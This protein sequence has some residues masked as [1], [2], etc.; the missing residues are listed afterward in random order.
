MTFIPLSASMALMGRSEL[1]ATEGS[2]ENLSNKSILQH[3]YFIIAVTALML[4]VAARICVLRRRNRPL[5]EFFSIKTSNFYDN[6]QAPGEDYTFSSSYQ[7][8]RRMHH[9]LTPLP[10]AHRPDRRIRPDRRVNAA[11][12]DSAG[13]RTG[14]PDDP[15]WDGKDILPAYN[16]YDRPPKYEFGGSV[17]PVQECTPPAVSHPPDD[18]VVESTGAIPAVED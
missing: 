11:D 17:P 12:I 18:A 7:P 6:S 8:S 1:L 16:I 9:H 3:L 15:D 13:R 5:T 2:T 10:S 14:G 4:L